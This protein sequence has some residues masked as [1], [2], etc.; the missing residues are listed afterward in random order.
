MNMQ[1][2]RHEPY[3]IKAI[4]QPLN[5]RCF[6]SNISQ[7]GIVSSLKFSAILNKILVL[8]STFNKVID[9]C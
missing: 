7:F 4:F 1:I 3:L 9:K 8:N 6:I 2:E 5:K